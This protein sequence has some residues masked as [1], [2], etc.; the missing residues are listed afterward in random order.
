MPGH[1]MARSIANNRQD[2]R[3]ST[4][5]LGGPPNG[6]VHAYP[7]PFSTRR[8]TSDRIAHRGLPYPATDGF[9]HRTSLLLVG[10]VDQLPSVGPGM[11][12]GSLI[13]SGIVPVVRMTEVFR[14]AA[15]SRIVTSAHRIN[16]GLM[17][18]IP[19]QEAQSDFY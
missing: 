16:E 3:E 2:G 13:E 6:K 14:Q 5:V 7:R 19:A 18:E 9:P 8:P 15:H 10:D 17:P 12:L 4:S 11:V 1:H